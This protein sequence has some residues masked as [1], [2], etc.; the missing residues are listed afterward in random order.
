MVYN[1][2]YRFLSSIVMLLVLMALVLPANMRA[3]A[4]GSLTVTPIT[5]NVVGLDSNN[6]AVGPNNFPV[7]VRVCNT[8]AT[9]SPNGTVT[10]NWD[11]PNNKFSGDPYINL[12]TGSLDVISL[13]L[14][15]AGSP[16]DC[17]DAYFE[18]SVT[19]NNGA[20]DHIRQYRITATDGV[21]SA[22]TPSPRE[23]YVE[24]LV[25][26]SRNAVNQIELSTNGVTYT[27]IAAG[28]T[29]TLMVGQTYFIRMSGSTATNGYEQI[30]SFVNLPNT[31][32]QVLSVAATY[33]AY[34]APRVPAIDDRLY[35]DGC[36]WDNNPLSP[37]YR[38]CLDVG[39]AGGTITVTYQVRILASSGAP[40]PLNTLIFD[41]SGSSY[42][43]NA[44]FESEVRYANIINASLVKS[45]APKIISPGDFSTLTFTITN[46]GTSA[47]SGVNFTDALPTNVAIA[48]TGITYTSCGTPSPA[49]GAL[50]IGQTSLSFSNIAVAAL[51]T[52]TIGVT[53]TSSTNGNYLNTTSSLRIGTVD[54]GSVGTDTLTV[55]T[56]PTTPASTCAAPV[57][58]ATWTMPTSGQGSGGAPPP[59]TSKVENVT[60]ATA[61]AGLPAAPVVSSSNIIAG[62]TTNAW[63]ILGGW[64]SL[65]T[66]PVA[67]STPY[68]EFSL[69]TRNY[70]GVSIAFDYLLGS[71]VGDWNQRNYFYIYS[72]ANSNTPTI[73]SAFTIGSINTWLS[74][75]TYTAPTTGTTTTR[76]RIYFLGAGTVKTGANANIDNIT[77][78]GCPPATAT[79]TLSKAFSPATI[80]RGGASTLTFTFANPNATPLTGVSFSDV[81][82]NGLVI[83][84]PNGLSIPTCTSGSI[85]GQTITANAGTSSISL[86]GGTMAANS[87]CSFSV[88]VRGSAAGSY[89]NTS[90]SIT[91]TESGPNTISTGYGTSG[92]TVLAPP[93][94]FKNFVPGSIYVNET[95]TISFSISNPNLST[96]LT[97]VQ[98][99]DAL[100]AGLVVS[101]PN[102]LTAP[103]C[104][105]GSISGQ[106][107]RAADGASSIS[108][109]G[110]SMTAGAFC[111]FSVNVTGT[112]TGY[113]VNSVTISSANGGTG[114]TSTSILQVRDIT[115]VL[116]LSKKV[117]TSATGPWYENIRTSSAVYYQFT[118][119][120][121]GDAPFNPVTI[122]DPILGL[123]NY[124]CTSS[125]VLSVA[126]TADDDHIRTCV[127][128][129]VNNAGASTIN[130][131]T[132][133][134]MYGGNPYTAAD[135]AAY[136]VAGNYGHLPSTY[137]NMNLYN[138]GG[139]F[140]LNG[141]TYLG[142]SVRTTDVDGQT[143]FLP[144]KSSD[145]GVDFIGAW[146]SGI[147]YATVTAEC[148]NAPCYLFSW[149]DWNNDLDF[150]DVNEIL[151]WTV[152]DGSNYITVD[153]PGTGL[154]NSGIYY[155][156]F[157]LY[158]DLP[159]NPQPNL[160][161]LST[162][163]IPLACEIE[164]YALQ[165]YPTAID[166]VHADARQPNART[167]PLLVALAV[168]PLLF[169]GM[170]V[171][172]VA[173]LR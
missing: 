123:T 103:V 54:T 172:W 124:I 96:T 29:M 28:G 158:D 87:S 16:G 63:Q 164:D 65:Q 67:T 120:N 47:I 30:E 13:S 118:I 156:R 46:P 169:T 151:D 38:T 27:T 79:P 136:Q 7:G 2:I 167:Q 76:F 14:A 133:T 102:G 39:R 42:H 159:L 88:S 100:P 150:N 71:G 165:M 25:S 99:T 106:T 59:Y 170:A 93:A 145:D 57:T 113:K 34:T 80:I 166:L 153:Y 69:D 105:F 74:S 168:L 122:S 10:F 89:T 155:A 125:G 114:N 95:S 56:Q 22:S 37:S 94:I 109:S 129:P 173:K 23:I 32:F 110:A 31:N 4:T 107:I 90:G 116:S 92:L 147:G 131:A 60:F 21:A 20:Y 117:S 3:S 36:L 11:D 144:L 77:I 127:V 6:V 68:F 18:V 55:A 98:F 75:G 138:E 142:A 1:K 128:G 62:N 72:Q 157:R 61:S 12:R 66:I 143:T 73:S 137:A 162:A 112:T 149:F 33:T 8:S 130:T 81:L 161:T 82:P 141:S 85:T 64:Y 58:I 49:T 35:G 15:A 5:W 132:V 17:R 160:T 119:E 163:G 86:T 115:P 51:G 84:T 45:F 108:M 148:P 152:V 91:S 43:Y 104:S 44:D 83:N 140:C 134:G 146:E 50:T 111:T 70:G 26:Q 40:Q 139:A 53:V 9:P 78:T 101:T 135:S 171:R 97:G 24:R 48:S 126:D 41:F 154:L 121:L 52:C 19:R